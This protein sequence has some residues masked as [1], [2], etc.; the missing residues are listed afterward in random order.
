VLCSVKDP[1]MV[2][3]RLH[4]LLRPGG[5]LRYLEHVA[6]ACGPGCLGTVTPIAIPS[7]RSSTPGSRW[8][9]L[10]GSGRCRSGRRFRCRS[11]YWAGRAGPSV[12]RAVSSAGRAVGAAAP[13]MPGSRS[14][15]G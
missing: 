3:G 8:R 12:V 7:A 9:I 11:C 5:E 13:A 14:R 1:A 15:A 4:S 10:G 6:S 2:L